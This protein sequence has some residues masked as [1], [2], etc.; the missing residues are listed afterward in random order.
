M[1]MPEVDTAEL[2]ESKTR[3][4]PAQLWKEIFTYTAVRK[5]TKA[6]FFSASLTASRRS[7]SPPASPRSPNF[8]IVLAYI[9][10]YS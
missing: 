1:I 8:K 9:L 2:L 6:L 4:W 3:P 7:F 5:A 10:V